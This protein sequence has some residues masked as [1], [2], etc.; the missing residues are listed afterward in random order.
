MRNCRIFKFYHP[1]TKGFRKN[2]PK[3]ISKNKSSSNLA[4]INSHRSQPY[5]ICSYTAS[6]QR[7][8]WVASQT[9][10]LPQDFH[11]AHLPLSKADREKKSLPEANSEFT[12]ENRWLEDEF[13]L[14]MDYFQGRTVSC[15]EFFR[16]TCQQ[17]SCPFQPRYIPKS[18]LPIQ[19]AADVCYAVDK[20]VEDLKRSHQTSRKTWWILYAFPFPAIK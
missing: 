19:F 8:P 17:V 4:K 11:Q 2:W 15:R 16:E 7:P 13:P 9:G 12:P 10:R 3:K 18:R 14:G 1:S 5:L 6:P 20:V